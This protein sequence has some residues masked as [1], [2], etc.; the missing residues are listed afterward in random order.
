MRFHDG[1][2]ILRFA[3]SIEQTGED[4]YRNLAENET[5]PDLKNILEHLAL[6]EVEHRRVFEN[7]IENSCVPNPVES[8][9][10]EYVAYMEAYLENAVFSG[11]SLESAKP[12]LADV[13][14]AIN[15]AIKAELDSI[16]FYHE[17]LP[18][19]PPS[20]HDTIRKIIEEERS[21]FL[22]LLGIKKV[23]SA[24]NR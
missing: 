14:S 6:D 7:M 3:V 16:L 24:A 21:H 4:F 18:F 11:K 19:I 13:Q 22:T 23:L 5:R 1:C 17:T 8:Y 15:F 12:D 20:Q 10:G 2:E 9:P